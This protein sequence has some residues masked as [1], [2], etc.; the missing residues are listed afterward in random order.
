MFDEELR[1]D[2]GRLLAYVYAD[3]RL[4]NAQLVAGGF[5]RT[6]EIEPNTAM[7]DVLG[8]MESRAATAGRGLWAAC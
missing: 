4:V 8:R 3:G 5:A 7:A 1:D 6:L 2:Y